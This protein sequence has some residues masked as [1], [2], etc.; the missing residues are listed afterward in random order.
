MAFMPPF[1]FLATRGARPAA[2]AASH[3]PRVA[4]PTVP[5]GLAPALDG[6]G[7][8]VRGRIA[9]ALP[10]IVALWGAGVLVLSVRYLG[11]FWIVRRLDRTARPAGRDVADRLAAL[12]RRMRISRPV[13]LLESALVEVPTVV[14]GLRPVIL[15]PVGAT[16]GL[17]AAQLESLPGPR[18]RARPPP[19]LPRGNS[20]R[21]RW[22]RSCSTT[23]R[24]GG[25]PIACASSGSTAAT[26]SRWRRPAATLSSTRAP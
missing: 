10:A 5:A 7:E 15:L 3:A 14:G 26:T 8:A 23:R 13:R 25:S 18:A 6:P 21:A 22:R 11:G 17:S 9:G 2:A 24:S 1:T 20:C 4:L 19:R 12:A 16:T